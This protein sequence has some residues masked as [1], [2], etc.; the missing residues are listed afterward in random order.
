MKRRAKVLVV[1]MLDSIHLVRWLEIFRDEPIDFFLVPSSPHR[2]IHRGLETLLHG[3]GSANFRLSRFAAN[4]GV[5]IWAFDR[6][7]KNRIKLTLINNIMRRQ[8]IDI[9]HALELQNAGYAMSDWIGRFGQKYPELKFII[10]NY[11]SDLYH[12]RR[13]PRHAQRIE[14]LLKQAGYYA[15]EC[16]RDVELALAMGFEGQVLPVIPNSG[17]FDQKLLSRE[18]S[19]PGAR[20]VIAVKGYQGWAGRA[21]LALRALRL[22]DQRLAHLQVR[23]YSANVSTMLLAW[24]LGRTSSIDVRSTLKGRLSHPEVLDMFGESLVYVGISRTDGIST[25]MLEAMAM[26]AIPVQTSSACCDEWFRNTGIAIKNLKVEEIAQGILR[27]LDMATSAEAAKENKR[28]ILIRASRDE[29][30]KSAL[31]FYR[32]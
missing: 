10:T 31:E 16:Q 11:G 12:F 25:S 30:A 7:F 8:N 13:F 3:D 2:A 26:G 29:I 14:R 23:I 20:S 5:I 6:L 24:H 17:G 27:A 22:I 1:G 32:I 21:H 15:A 28:T 19:P 18:L 4:L 9:A